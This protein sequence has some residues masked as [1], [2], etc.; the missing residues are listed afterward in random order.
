MNTHDAAITTGQAWR[1]ALQHLLHA[2]PLPDHFEEVV[3]PGFGD[4]SHEA[5]LWQ[6]LE[7][8]PGE[9]IGVTGL[10]VKVSLP[11]KDSL[12]EYKAVECSYHVPVDCHLSYTH[13]RGFAEYV[14]EKREDAFRQ[15]EEYIETNA[16]LFDE[17]AKPPDGDG[18][19]GKHLSVP[20]PGAPP[21]CGIKDCY[22]SVLDGTHYCNEHMP[23]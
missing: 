7:P 15:I 16:Y 5:Y 13:L 2:F 19:A 14:A 11:I 10:T 22:N 8:P 17:N 18:C 21:Q 23:F 12:R 1:N 20:T 3:L 4:R 9:Q 6:G